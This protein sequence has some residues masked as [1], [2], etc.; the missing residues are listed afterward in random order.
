MTRQSP[1][2]LVLA[3]HCRVLPFSWC[4]LHRRR[5]MTKLADPR[6]LQKICRGTRARAIEG[7]SNCD[8][9]GE[10]SWASRLV[11]SSRFEVETL[12]TQPG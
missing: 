9:E 6:L 7:R 1:A 2:T 3:N 8:S 5:R 4:A 10:V 12:R 11:T